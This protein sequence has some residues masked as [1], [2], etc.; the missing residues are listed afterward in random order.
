MQGWR[1]QTGEKSLVYRVFKAKYFLDCEF[2]QAFMGNNPSYVW[3]SI[4]SSYLESSTAWIEM[5]GW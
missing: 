3:R 2:V 4:L 1:L 5:V